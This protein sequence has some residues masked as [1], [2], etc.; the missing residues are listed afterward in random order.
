MQVDLIGLY[1]FDKGGNKKR[2]EEKRNN[3]FAWPQPSTRGQN[4]TDGAAGSYRLSI[5]FDK[6]LL[7]I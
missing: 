3:T 4:R 7:Q 5:Q 6:T 1:V 2:G